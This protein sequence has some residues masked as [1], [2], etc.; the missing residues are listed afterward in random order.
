MP[1]GWVEACLVK[2]RFITVTEWRDDQ[3]ELGKG[4]GEGT[5]E[6]AA[7]ESSAGK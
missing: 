2:R 7:G 5:I 1:E 4:E 6:R 3:R